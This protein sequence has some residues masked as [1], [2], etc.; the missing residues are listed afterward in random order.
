MKTYRPHQ[1]PK[2]KRFNADPSWE[3]AERHCLPPAIPGIE[4][5]PVSFEYMKE[6][7][8]NCED[9]LEGENA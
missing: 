4:K 9:Y 3:Y 8:N 1:C 2:C 7:V 5:V 6:S